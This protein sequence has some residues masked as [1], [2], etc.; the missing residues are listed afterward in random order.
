MRVSSWRAWPLTVCRA[1]W[2]YET[3]PPEPIPA[4]P[5]NIAAAPRGCRVYHSTRLTP[6]VTAT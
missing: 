1:R 6:R 3:T 2:G 4:Q 5:A